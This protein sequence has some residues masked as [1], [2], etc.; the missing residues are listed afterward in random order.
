MDA[1]SCRACLTRRGF[2]EDVCCPAD[3]CTGARPE[4]AVL[5]RSEGSRLRS[6]ADRLRA[7]DEIQLFKHSRHRRRRN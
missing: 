4:P 1:P 2:E 5:T 7:A 3:R 6:L